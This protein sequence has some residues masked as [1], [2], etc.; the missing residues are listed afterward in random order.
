MKKLRYNE[1]GEKRM[2]KKF[3]DW[4]NDPELSS[5]VKVTTMPLTG[6]HKADKILEDLENGFS[7]SEKGL[8]QKEVA[9]SPHKYVYDPNKVQ[10]DSEG[11]TYFLDENGYLVYFDSL[12]NVYGIMVNEKNEATEF[13]SIGR[14]ER[15]YFKNPEHTIGVLKDGS[16][17]VYDP[18]TK[19]YVYDHKILSFPTNEDDRTR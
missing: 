16:V 18:D 2:E 9:L 6:E 13:V 10:I 1:R 12:G 7:Y 8:L 3:F 17:Y 14:G 5:D 4:E 11:R 19:E 15:L